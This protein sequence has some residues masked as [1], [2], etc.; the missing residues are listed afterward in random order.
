L[1]QQEL[2]RYIKPMRT[3][4]V[5]LFISFGSFGQTY[6]DMMSLVSKD[7]FI[8]V[9]VENNYQLNNEKSTDVM[10]MYD[11]IEGTQFAVYVSREEGEV[12]NL[13]VNKKTSVGIELNNTPYDNIYNEVK[14][15]CTFDRI[16]K[17]MNLDYACYLCDD[18]KFIG[19]IGFAIWDGWGY[20]MQ[21]K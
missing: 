20:I 14:E 2:R 5:L 6:D 12:F 9:M 21:M 18:A 3:L 19:T 7:A 16:E 1:V 4:I 13:S 17:A 11:N 8:K 15:K 10:T